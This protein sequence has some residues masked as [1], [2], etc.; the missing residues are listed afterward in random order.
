[1]AGRKIMGNERMGMGRGICKLVRA[2]YIRSGCTKGD[3][4]LTSSCDENTANPEP[5]GLC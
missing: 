1:M 5:V 3:G 2:G 4:W